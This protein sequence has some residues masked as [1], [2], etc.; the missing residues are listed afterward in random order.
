MHGFARLTQDV[1][2]FVA[3]APENVERL[4]HSLHTV[5]HDASIEEISSS[6]YSRIQ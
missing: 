1:D 3:L 5:Y 6:D 2:L 4:K